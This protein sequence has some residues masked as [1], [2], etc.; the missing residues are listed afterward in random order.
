MF[1]ISSPFF[2]TNLISNGCQGEGSDE[3]SETSCSSLSEETTISLPTA[4]TLQ[5]AAADAHRGCRGV[6]V[7]IKGPRGSSIFTQGER[8][9][10]RR[11]RR[12]RREGVCQ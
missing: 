5:S 10:G 11:R 8:S 2:I 6:T 9:R 12:R 4:A 1:H 7:T 3:E